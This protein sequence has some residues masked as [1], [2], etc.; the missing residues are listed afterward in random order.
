[1]V[2]ATK[3]HMDMIMSYCHKVVHMSI[4]MLIVHVAFPLF[5]EGP[6]PD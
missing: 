5:L 3:L 6:Y 1:M 4:Q 2:Y